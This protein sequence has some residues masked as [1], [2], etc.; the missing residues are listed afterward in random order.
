VP[1]LVCV[2][3]KTN[4]ELRG[5]VCSLDRFVR[6]HAHGRSTSSSDRV[7]ST[8]YAQVI[9]PHST[10]EAQVL[11]RVPP[12]CPTIHIES[13]RIIELS[14]VLETT[15][16]LPSGSFNMHLR[17][18]VELG[19]IPHMR[20]PLF[21]EQLEAQ[22]AAAQQQA[23]L[24]WATPDGIIQQAAAHAVQ[25]AA[26]PPA[27]DDVYQ[28]DAEPDHQQV[29]GQTLYPCFAVPSAPP[30]A[31]TGGTPQPTESTSLMGASAPPM[32][33]HAMVIQPQPAQ[34]ASP[35]GGGA[36]FCAP[37]AF[38]PIPKDN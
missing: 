17:I 2:D 31:M 5:V 16:R 29:F 36:V 23:A 27:Y 6:Y 33:G 26:P 9:A 1:F 34:W 12:C 30:P 21:R 35:T 18:P 8:P 25:P 14:Y 7:S 4:S 38:A 28:G 22:S 15:V 3:N 11:L 24:A 20:P 32:P 13:A 19:T 10:F 37:A